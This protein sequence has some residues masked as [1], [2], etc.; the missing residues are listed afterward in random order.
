VTSSRHPLRM[1]IG[2]GNRLRGDDG[3]GLAVMS[4][5]QQNAPPTWTVWESSGDPAQLIDAWAG[6]VHVI[7]VDAVVT[8]TAPAGTIH[9]WDISQVALPALT[10]KHSSH[11]LG[12]AE[13]AELARALNALPP[14][15]EVLGIE[16][17]SCD[18]VERLS[19]AVATAVELIARELMQNPEQISRL[20]E[21]R[22]DA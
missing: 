3:A 11:A 12:L 4:L 1:I 2:I 19:P 6:A 22:H 7:A 8:E 20:V 15:I 13:A 14:I 17:T 16:V 18:Y 5:V 21:E 10:Q 9:Y